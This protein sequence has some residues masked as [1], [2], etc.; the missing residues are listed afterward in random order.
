MKP[1]YLS[2]LALCLMTSGCLFAQDQES[3]TSNEKIYFYD[4]F[5]PGTVHFA[6][7]SISRAKLNYNF[8]LQDMQFLN[9]ANE[10]LSLVR[11]PDLM[12]AKIGDDIFAPVDK[13]YAAVVLDG[14]VALLQKKHIVTKRRAT[15]A[16]GIEN[17]TDV[18]ME[19]VSLVSF[20]AL[21]TSHEFTEARQRRIADNLIHR[22]EVTF[23]LMKD[24][25]IYPATRRNF[26][27]L[28]SEIRPELKRF[29][30]EHPVDFRN[31]EHLRGLTRFGNSLLTAQ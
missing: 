12:Y 19:D 21:P 24:K 17:N 16:Y 20:V 3:N 22:I 14:P 2:V 25:K 18:G 15:G 30:S 10:V 23:Y 7:G 6:D 28:Y 8:L 27:R 11:Q 4:E 9:A 5:Q 29:L 13:G 1:Y 26:L 31:G